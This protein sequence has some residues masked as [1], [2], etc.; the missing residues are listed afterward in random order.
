MLGIGGG[1]GEMMKA[2]NQ[3]ICIHLTFPVQQKPSTQAQVE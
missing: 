2:N 3:Q 1:F